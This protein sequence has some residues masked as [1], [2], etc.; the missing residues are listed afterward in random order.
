MGEEKKEIRKLVVKEYLRSEYNI[1]I[2]LY[3]KNLIEATFCAGKP[4][5]EVVIT[6]IQPS[7]NPQV[8]G[9]PGVA[10]V[11]R[12][13]KAKEAQMRARREM[14]K[15]DS[16]LRVIERLIEDEDKKVTTFE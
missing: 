16:V 8:P 10:G 1:H 14:D 2:I 12:K 4:Q 7:G 13:I 5:D 9:A 11:E 6:L 3:V 15:Q